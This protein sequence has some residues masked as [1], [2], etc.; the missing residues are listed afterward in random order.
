MR[1]IPAVMA[2][3]VLLSA[4]AAQPVHTGGNAQK[5]AEVNAELGLRYMMQ[6]KNDVALEKLDR[7]LKQNP[8]SANAHHYLAELY[9]RLDKP[10]EADRHYQRALELDGK[11]TSLQNNYGVFLCNQKRYD[12]AEKRFLEVLD[13]PVYNGR[14]RTLENLGLCMKEKPDLKKAETYF[15]KALAL[16][17]NLV[18][19]LYAMAELSFAEGNY[20]SARAYLQRYLELAPHD[21]GTLWLGV[22]IER[23][24]GDLDAAASYEMQL[25]AN[26]PDSK[27]TRLL[28]ER[29]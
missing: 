5:S 25:K 24:L 26:F 9:R 27:E 15:R 17:K 11:N 2:A 13:D 4:C 3:A 1:R 29:P 12:E 7:A 22:Q 6:G 20:L 8:D 28:Y 10:A 19:S 18:K 21:P 14:A 23:K 16:D